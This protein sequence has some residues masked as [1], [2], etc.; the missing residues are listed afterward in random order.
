MQQTGTG[1]GHWINMLVPKIIRRRRITG[2]VA[3]SGS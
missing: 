1:T 2:Q 3:T